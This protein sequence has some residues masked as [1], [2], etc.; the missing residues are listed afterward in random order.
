MS[1][2]R[3]CRKERARPDLI[4]TFLLLFLKSHAAAVRE[5]IYESR[6]VDKIINKLIKIIYF[7]WLLSRV[8]KLLAHKIPEHDMRALV[9][10]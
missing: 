1:S 3:F 10:D 9:I 7:F 2:G 5:G 6:H 4:Y 8:E